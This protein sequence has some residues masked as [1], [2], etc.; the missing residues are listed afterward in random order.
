MTVATN[1]SILFISLINAA[2]NVLAHTTMFADE[3]VADSDGDAWEDVLDD[4]FADDSDDD[5]VDEGDDKTSDMSDIETA[6][7]DDNDDEEDDLDLGAFDDDEE[8][9]FVDFVEE[10]DEL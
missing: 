8:D 7:S 4:D 3:Q 2:N 1:P 10:Y 5:I 9:D 6:A